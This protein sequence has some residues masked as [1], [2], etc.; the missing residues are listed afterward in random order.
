MTHLV[1]QFLF[2]L[3]ALVSGVFGFEFTTSFDDWVGNTT[4]R[5]SWN[6][7][8][9]DPSIYD[10]TLV[11]PRDMYSVG[12]NPVISWPTQWSNKYAIQI[13]RFGDRTIQVP[14]DSNVW[15]GVYYWRM[16]SANGV[17][18]ATQQDIPDIEFEWQHQP[19]HDNLLRSDPQ[20]S[21]PRRMSRFV[22]AKKLADEAWCDR[23]IYTTIIVVSD[24]GN[25]S[26]LGKTPMIIGMVLALIFL[27]TLP[28]LVWLLLRYRRRPSQSFEKDKPTPIELGGIPNSSVPDLAPSNASVVGS[29]ITPARSTRTTTRQV[30]AI[31]DGEKQLVTI[32]QDPTPST[33]T[34]EPN[35]FADPSTPNSPKST[36]RVFVTTN[37][38]ASDYDPPSTSINPFDPL[39]SRTN[40]AATSFSRPF[41]RGTP[42]VD[43]HTSSVSN[44]GG[45]RDKLQGP[46]QRFYSERYPLSE[47][48]IT[49]R[50]I[51]PGRAVDMGTLGRD[52]VPDVDE[53]G[54]LPPD[55]FQATQT[56]PSR[57][58]S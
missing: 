39:L 42:T 15:P 12:I 21:T 45:P 14:L 16:D 37:P 3:L 11:Q 34:V 20:R 35:P 52:H 36:R 28:I 38:S 4:Y 51:V 26:P 17:I 54:L 46:E 50:I 32:S 27:I 24:G 7:S 19:N 56:T 40:T 23:I 8:V 18:S 58:S 10:L 49:S 57:Q 1:I 44:G 30:W 5:I 33:N 13:P 6:A 2:Y 31:V 9:S 41:S 22:T 47:E 48:D 55:Y 25:G 29:T 53:N 43:T